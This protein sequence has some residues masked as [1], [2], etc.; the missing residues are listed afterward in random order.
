M[1]CCTA[2]GGYAWVATNPDHQAWKLAG[3]GAVVTSI[4]LAGVVENLTYSEGAVWAAEGDA[5]AVVRIDATTNAKRAYR[6]GHHLAGVAAH[7][8]VVAVGVQESAHDAT[9]GLN[10][11]VVTVVLKDD[12]LDWTS[13]DPA[14]TQSSFNPYQVQFH[15]ATCAKL[16]NY[17]DA[18]GAAGLRLVPEVAAGWPTV[19]DGGPDVHVPGPARLPLLTT[20]ERAGEGRVVP[21]R[22]RALPLAPAAARPVEPRG[23]LRRHR[24]GCLPRW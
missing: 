10:G 20:V 15:Y 3:S 19:S 17:R 22:D 1:Q 23:A 11:R 14:A 8:G 6:V 2:G 9:A 12:Y 13:P 24:R 4:Q 5:G 16:F 21:A 18:A 7:N